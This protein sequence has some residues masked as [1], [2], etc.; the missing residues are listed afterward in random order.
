MSRLFLD[1]NIILD[2]LRSDF[3]LSKAIISLCA[4]R[5]HKAVISVYVA[6]EVEDNL[7]LDVYTLNRS[8]GEKLLDRYEEMLKRLRPE[9]VPLA[10]RTEVIFA[11]RVIRHIHDAPVLAAAINARPDWLLHRNRKHFSKAVADRTGLRLA[12]P[13]EFF[14]IIHAAA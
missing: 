3:G 7:L 10:D 13:K 12:T 1:S 14:R 8:D 6:G 4:A 2:A 11:S 9:I 5:I